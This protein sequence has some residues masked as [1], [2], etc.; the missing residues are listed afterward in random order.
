MK[1]IIKTI[2][3]HSRKMTIIMLYD[4][5]THTHTVRKMVKE[6]RFSQQTAVGDLQKHVGVM[7]YP[8]LQLDFTSRQTN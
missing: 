8:N 3:T 2:K 5:Y 4:Y 7:K 6:A 1:T